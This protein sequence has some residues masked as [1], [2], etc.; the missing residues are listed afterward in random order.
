[1]G[2]DP[3]R[4]KITVT[5]D[6]VLK[7][8]EKH[9][10]N[11]S[12]I[13][14]IAR[15]VVAGVHGVEGVWDGKTALSYVHQADLK[16]LLAD[17]VADG[18]LIL[19]PGPEWVERGAPTWN[20]RKGGHYYALPQEARQWQEAADQRR[21]QARQETAERLARNKLVELHPRQYA[22]L[23]NEYLAAYDRVGAQETEP[24]A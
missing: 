19:R 4:L 3:A 22:D 5:R 8:L 21:A 6:D 20:I 2:T 17:M 10:S 7:G 1:M 14:D 18:S 13:A 16:R 24:L 11:L 23:V 12:T 9:A 15:A